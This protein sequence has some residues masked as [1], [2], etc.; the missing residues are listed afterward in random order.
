MIAQLVKRRLDGTRDFSPSVGQFL[1]SSPPRPD[2]F[3]DP[4]CYQRCTLIFFVVL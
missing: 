4:A 1:Y 2:G 3:W